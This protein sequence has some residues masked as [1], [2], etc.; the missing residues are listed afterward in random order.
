MKKKPTT[1]STR[2]EKVV[3][4]KATMPCRITIRLTEEQMQQI[5]HNAALKGYKPS[6]YCRQVILG[7]KVRDLSPETRKYRQT[8]INLG[9]NLNQLVRHMNASGAV[10]SD[11]AQAMSLIAD[12]KQ[13]KSNLDKA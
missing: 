11:I 9:N 12:I 2:Q 6:A 3:E 1:K 7:R 10:K 8:L 4:P 13:L 5:T